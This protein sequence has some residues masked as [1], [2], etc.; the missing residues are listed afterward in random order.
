MRRSIKSLKKNTT[1]LVIKSFFKSKQEKELIKKRRDFYSQFF[2]SKGD[3]YFDVGANFGNRIE[4]II[5][6]GLKIVAVE[7]QL[8]CV[9]FLR[10]KYGNKIVVVPNGL[11][12]IEE[13][14]T[15]YISNSHVISSFSKDWIDA[16]KES[17]RFRKYNWNQERQ[18][19]M[20]TL[21]NLI[22][23]Y[24]L[25]KFIK[26]DVEGFE[27]EVLKGLSHAVDFISFEYTVPEREQDVAD[28]IDRIIEIS[29]SENVKFNYSV[30][31][32]M[33]WALDKWL[34]PLQMKE[35]IKQERFIKTGFG[36]IYSKIDKS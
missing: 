7:P 28:C 12:S 21:D 19:E 34:T 17:G 25:P 3:V 23:Q 6:K 18:I 30:G 2:T 35:E 22:N 10:K 29:G 1:L 14:K 24:G 16:T 15:M 31:E 33:V 20:T 36:D 32:G 26:I 8:P 11:S 27:L 13:V 5:D 4:P 9:K